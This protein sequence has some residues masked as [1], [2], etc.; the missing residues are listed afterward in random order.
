MLESCAKAVKLIANDRAIRPTINFFIRLFPSYFESLARFLP[1]TSV[2]VWLAHGV[3]GGW[4]CLGTKRLLRIAESQQMQ[5][6]GSRKPGTGS[7]FLYFS[8]ATTNSG[9]HSR[10]RL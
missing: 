6:A 7:R 9:A 8:R 5:N 1:L 2:R 3:V 10:A 4:W